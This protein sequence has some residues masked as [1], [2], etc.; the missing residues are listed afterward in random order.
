VNART[1]Y[2]KLRS[3]TEF[4]VTDDHLKLLRRAY[5]SWDDCEF[6]APEIDCKRPYGNSDVLDDIGE[7]LG[8]GPWRG[9]DEEILPDAER[10]FTQLHAETAVALQVAL[11]TGKFEAGRYTR[12]PYSIGWHRTDETQQ[13][14]SLR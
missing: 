14:E 13:E 6:G 7:I 1:V 12:D 5:V 4:T 10:A 8:A 3:V 11:A 9:E 2:D